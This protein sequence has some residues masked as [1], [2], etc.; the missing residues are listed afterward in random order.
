MPI[1]RV[2]LFRVPDEKNVPL[3]QEAYKTLEKE[4]QKASIFFRIE[5]NQPLTYRIPTEH[6]H[7]R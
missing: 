4:N 1:Q 7:K 5:S 3:L 6:S 2:T